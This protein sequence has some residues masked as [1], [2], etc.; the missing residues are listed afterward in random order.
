MAEV[1]PGIWGTLS[2]LIRLLEEI[3]CSCRTEV[4]FFL[5]ATGLGPHSAPRSHPKLLAT[6]LSLSLLMTWWLLFQGQQGSISVSFNP[7]DL[8]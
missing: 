3:F 2:D 5:V 1:S 4:P 7:S 6:T 8:F